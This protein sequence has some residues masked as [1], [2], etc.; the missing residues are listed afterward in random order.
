[1]RADELPFLLQV[2]DG[3]SPRIDLSTFDPKTRKL[4]D[5]LDLSLTSGGINGSSPG[6]FRFDTVRAESKS[7]AFSMFTKE[8]EKDQ[9]EPP[10]IAISG[11]WPLEDPKPGHTE[12][13]SRL[14]P[15]AVLKKVLVDEKGKFDSPKK[16]IPGQHSK[17]PMSQGGRAPAK[18]VRSLS[19]T[20]PEKKLY[21]LAD[22]MAQ[23]EEEEV[24]MEVEKTAQEKF[25]MTE[26]GSLLVVDVGTL[27]LSSPLLPPTPPEMKKKVTGELK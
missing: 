13:A 21:S 10:A 9:E 6:R 24:W 5:G 18:A 2:L 19:C 25:V 8:G 7:P 3:H 26:E 17:I 20:A 23:E 16:S 15:T 12:G 11:V 4:L 14:P 22:S 1:M 27:S